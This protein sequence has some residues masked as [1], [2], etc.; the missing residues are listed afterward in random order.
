MKGRYDEFNSKQE[1]AKKAYESVKQEKSMVIAGAFGR[2]PRTQLLEHFTILRNNL[3]DLYLLYKLSKINELDSVLD[4]LSNLT[5]EFYD[6]AQKIVIIDTMVCDLNNKSQQFSRFNFG[7]KD[8]LA[9]QLSI[10]R[11][12]REAL[13]NA[14]K[15]NLLEKGDNNETK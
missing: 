6:L 2:Y 11:F 1:L 15:H 14:L 8:K 10:L 5:P 9:S 4:C 12:K 13:V 7:K 3:D